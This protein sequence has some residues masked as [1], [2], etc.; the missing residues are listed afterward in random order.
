MRAARQD[1][2]ARDNGQSALPLRAFLGHD[3]GGIGTFGVSGG[4]SKDE[5]HWHILVVLVDCENSS[6]TATLGFLV[7]RVKT[8]GIGTF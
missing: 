6:A 3:T 1:L 8:S 7:D 5:W 4:Q 2:A